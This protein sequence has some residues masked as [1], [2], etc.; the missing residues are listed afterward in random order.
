MSA[1]A[2]LRQD[3]FREFK[4]D[5]ND[6]S[7][8]GVNQMWDEIKKK[9]L[10][11][12][13]RGEKLSPEAKK[14][15]EE[16]EERKKREENSLEPLESPKSYPRRKKRSERD[17]VVL[18]VPKGDVLLDMLEKIKVGDLLKIVHA[19]PGLE[20][21]LPWDFWAFVY[22]R[23]FGRTEEYY[24]TYRKKITEPKAW[25]N[26]TQRRYLREKSHSNPSY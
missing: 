18:I 22:R 11:K 12:H 7:T 19:S 6:F 13:Q 15:A 20:E 4:G 25:I 8:V 14:M 10:Q 9:T 16:I 3:F 24:R 5:T 17:Q 2:K 23:S 26:M 1:T 21:I